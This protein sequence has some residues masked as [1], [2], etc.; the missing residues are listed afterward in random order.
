MK[1]CALVFLFFFSALL[2]VLNFPLPANA[3]N[4]KLF[5]S[6]E[7]RTISGYAYYSGGGRPAGVTVFLLG[8]AG[9]HLGEAVT[10]DKGEFE[11]EAPFKAD[12]L[13]SLNTGDG[14]TASWKLT[15]GE[16]PDDLARLEAPAVAS[17][18]IG[19]EEEPSDQRRNH[20][21][22]EIGFSPVELQKLVT[23]AISDAIKP[24]Q[25]QITLY[26]SQVDQYES[27]IRF[28][29]ILGGLGYILGMAGLFM[30]IKGRKSVD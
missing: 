29:D 19:N 27:R 20:S 10:S 9:E 22:S 23:A 6:V 15:A 18:R 4:L 5:G 13:L 30:M 12:F 28:H 17:P 25:Q 24:L 2:L 3:H 7:G 21:L 14:H 1:R 16:F 8:P 26:R 11:F